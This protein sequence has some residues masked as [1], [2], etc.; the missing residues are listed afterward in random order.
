[1]TLG[2]KWYLLRAAEGQGL[3][4]KRGETLLC[5]L[6]IQSILSLESVKEMSFIL[7]GSTRM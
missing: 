7:S 2:W 1:M 5:S 6:L 3:G 4:E